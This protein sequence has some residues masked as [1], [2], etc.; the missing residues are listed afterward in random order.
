MNPLKQLTRLLV[1]LC[2]T[3]VINLQMIPARAAMVETDQ[4]I[5]S[6]EHELRVDELMVALDTEEMQQKLM[7]LGVDPQS[8]RDRIS[9]LTDAELQQLAAMD[10]QPV[11]SG[12]A[13]IALTVFIVFVI[14]DLLG[15]TD[16]F[17]FIKSVNR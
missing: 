6:A 8:A 14:T 13:G 10:Q 12:A 16:I 7:A 17:P 11:G 3:V 1:I 9:Q 15:A 4:L 2:I 5:H